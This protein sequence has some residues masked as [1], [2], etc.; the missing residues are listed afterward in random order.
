M[1]E[2]ECRPRRREGVLTQ[3]AA[4]ADTLILLDLEGGQYY[5]LDEVGIRVWQLT[6]GTRGVAEI[7]SLIAQEFNAPAATIEADIQE[8]LMDLIHEKL[9]DEDIGTAESLRQTA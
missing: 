4:D 8:L 1:I 7:A 6:D 2:L 5:A 3:Q 9:V